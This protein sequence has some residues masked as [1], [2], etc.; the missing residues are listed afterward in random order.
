MPLPAK[1]LCGAKT[2]SGGECTQPA[3]ANGRCRMH[4]GRSPRGVAHPSFKTGR[5]SR[6]IPSRL[7]HSYEQALADPRKL[8]LDNEL[9]LLICRNEELLATLHSGES[10]ALWK[11]L[12]NAKREMDK[13]REKAKTAWEHGDFQAQAKHRA[14]VDDLQEEILRLIERG[15]SE[16]ERWDELRTNME[17]Q[18]KLSESERK[19]LVEAHQ[20]ATVEEIMALMGALLAI[21][22]KHVPDPATRRAIG[23]DMDVLVNGLGA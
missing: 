11:R 6:S 20:V 18:R 19:R 5:F 14:K 3:M 23:Y 12:R 9:A 15:A 8:E 13:A 7:S 16:A 17:Q 22:K 10:G 4:G 1:H 21:I 2:R